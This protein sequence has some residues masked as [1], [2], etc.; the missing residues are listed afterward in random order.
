MSE[1][2]YILYNLNVV[3]GESWYLSCFKNEKDPN[4]SPILQLRCS[5]YVDP[6]ED[7]SFHYH[8]ISQEIFILLDG[9]L[10]MIINDKPLT[11]RNR[12]ILLVQPEVSHSI[13]GGRGKIRHLVFKIPHKEDKWILTKSKINY[14]KIRIDMTNKYFKANIDSSIGFFA[15]LNKKKYQNRWLLGIGEALYKTKHLSLAYMNFKDKDDYIATNHKETYHYHLASTEWYFTIKGYQKLLINN[16]EITIYPGY[17]LRIPEK[18]SHT[19]LLYSYP[20]EGI[21]LRTPIIPEDKVI[22]RED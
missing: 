17:L 2:K 1:N 20:F 6:W 11:L 7:S 22:L 4:F 16:D 10:W 21:T 13:V 15:D 8:T 9:E 5:N 14:N 3:E 18:S 19:L 12:N